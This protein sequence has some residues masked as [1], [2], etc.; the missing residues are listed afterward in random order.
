MTTL[1]IASALVA[2][3][4]S[5]FAQAETEGATPIP[6]ACT[7][8]FIS[9][10]D[11][12]QAS[13]VTVGLAAESKADDQTFRGSVVTA[14][15]SCHSFI[16]N[17]VTIDPQTRK[18]FAGSCSRAVQKETGEIITVLLTPLAHKAECEYL[19]RLLD[20]DDSLCEVSRAEN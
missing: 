11:S 18:W 10:F 17:Y 16:A 15:N 1:K 4:F 8:Q 13:F 14:L 6:V 19:Q 5:A 20:Q 3:L 9:D 12:T 7:E 2:I